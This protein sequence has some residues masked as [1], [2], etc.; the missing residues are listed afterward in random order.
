LR[1]RFYNSNIGTTR[2]GLS[3]RCDEVGECIGKEVA[4]ALNGD[5]WY[6]KGAEHLQVVREFPLARKY[7]V[8]R[9]PQVFFIAARMR[10]LSSITTKC[11]AG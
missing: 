6:R 8:T 7:V 9:S 10:S 11:A 2:S 3:Y 5:I 1:R 4:D